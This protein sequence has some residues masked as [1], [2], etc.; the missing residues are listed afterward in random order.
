[1]SYGFGAHRMQLNALFREGDFPG[2]VRRD[3]VDFVDG[4]AIKSIQKEMIENEESNWELGGDYEYSFANGSRLAFLFV[5]NDEIRNSVRER[6]LA[7]PASSP[8]NKNLYIDSQRQTKE[9]IL[10]TNYNFSLTEGQSLRI[11]FERAINELN[12]ALFIASPFGT[13]TASE[14]TAAYP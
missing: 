5:A 12:S 14:N 3:F 7:D 9:L 6:F 13:E 1:M 11:G 2:P 4:A 8:L 10:Q